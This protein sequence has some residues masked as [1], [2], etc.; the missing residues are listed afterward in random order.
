[1]IRLFTQKVSFETS[2]TGFRDLSSLE[3]ATN[4]FLKSSNVISN[5]TEYHT[6][7]LSPVLGQA[8]MASTNDAVANTGTLTDANNEF[9]VIL[10]DS[11][12]TITAGT[13]K[14]QRRRILKMGGSV[15]ELIV[16]PIWAILPDNT[17]EYLIDRG[18]WFT[19]KIDYSIKQN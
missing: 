5:G 13:G 6:Y 16:T 9:D 3:N 15:N 1:M 17:S 4:R 18:I 8:T 7:T 2:N 14:N 19:V 12:L 10:V 11:I